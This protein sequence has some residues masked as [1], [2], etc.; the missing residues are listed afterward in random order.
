MARST[1]ASQLGST[2]GSTWLGGMTGAVKIACI[3]A[4]GTSAAKGL[5]PVKHS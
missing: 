5:C 3:S 4:Y 2:R 1:S